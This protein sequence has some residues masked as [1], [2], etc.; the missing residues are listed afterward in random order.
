MHTL[1]N[2]IPNK[3]KITALD[4]ADYAPKEEWVSF[5]L[6]ELL[7]EG[8]IV[9][10]KQFKTTLN[11]LD[12]D[13]FKGKSV[14]VHYDDELILPAWIFM[15]ITSRFLE[16]AQ[17]VSFGPMENLKLQAWLKQLENTNFAHLKD[18]RVVI[19]ARPGIPPE[20]YAKITQLLS[21]LV[22]ALMYGE[23][24]LPKVIWKRK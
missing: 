3:S 7:Y 23:V 8:L 12:L 13:V 15:S 6:A 2:N 1:H 16:V 17:N 22:K 14:A 11:N 19:V 18:E 5:D 4:L 24:G 9:K 21:P 10:E 20:V